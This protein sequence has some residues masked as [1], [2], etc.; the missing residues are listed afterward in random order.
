MTTSQQQS[1]IPGDA[2]PT[3]SQ[4]AAFQNSINAIRIIGLAS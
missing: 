2:G 3:Q 1:E 4:Q